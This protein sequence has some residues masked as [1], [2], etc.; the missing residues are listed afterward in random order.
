MDKDQLAALDRAATQGV[1]ASD[2]L[3][4]EG[5]YGSGA[6]VNEGF[7]TTAIY[8]DK[9]RCLFDCLNGDAIE[10]EEGYGD[11]EDYV[12][13]YDRTSDANAALIV[14]LVNLY[15]TGKLVLID[16]GAVEAMQVGAEELGAAAPLLGESAAGDMHRAAARLRAAI[17]ALG[18]K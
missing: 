7:E 17:S 10:V 5:S 14:A 1:W 15:R 3:W 8:D 18:V 6:D 16:D 9:G 13:A 4:S 2:T 11:E 12:L